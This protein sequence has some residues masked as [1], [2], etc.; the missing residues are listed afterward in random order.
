MSSSLTIEGKEYI[1]ATIAGKE[2]DY[3]KDYL[4]LLIKQGKIDGKKIAN[5]W[6]VYM[7][8][9]KQFFE[10]AK[11]N[12]VERREKI[13]VERKIE[14]EEH[15]HVRKRNH[16]H[17]ALVE[18]LAIV[19]IGL[20]LGATGYFGSTVNL[21]SVSASQ[22]SFFEHVAV[23][24][25][26][27]FA[28]G[29]TQVAGVD[30]GVSAQSSVVQDT[31]LERVS[32]TRESLL[33]MPESSTTAMRIEAVRDS[34][35]DQVGVALDPENPDTGVIIPKFKNRDGEAYRFLM[36]PVKTDENL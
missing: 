18:T 11:K 2:F 24:F 28:R 3:T 6:Y 26:S 9:A 30:S 13:R 31:S 35:S 12:Q 19:V 33:V 1:P 16:G 15:V 10:D 34:F 17:T 8:S 7:P 4:L 25:Y 20:S 27:F 29:E 14:L 36:V 21:S 5:R 23:S 32:M 22:Q